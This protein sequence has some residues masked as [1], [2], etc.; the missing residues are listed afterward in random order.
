MNEVGFVITFEVA[1]QISAL[2]IDPAF[3][4]IQHFI[5]ASDR[6]ILIHIILNTGADSNLPIQRKIRRALV[7]A[8]DESVV[9]RTDGPKPFWCK[10]VL[11]TQ[12]KMPGFVVVQILNSGLC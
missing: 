7:G 1:F 12:G 11:G 5:S 4:R 9:G 8:T 10:P 6:H 3:S 2:L